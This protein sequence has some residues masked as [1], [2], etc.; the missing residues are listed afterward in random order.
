[1]PSGPPTVSVVIPTYNGARFV[2]RA[3]DSVLVQQDEVVDVVVVDD[4]STDETVDI[5]AR[6]EDVRLLRQPHRGVAAARNAGIAA[7]RAPFV[8]FCDHD[9]EWLLHKA[10]RQAEHLREDPGASAVLCFADAVCDD[11]VPWPAW[12]PRGRDGHG[13]MA[14]AAYG[15]FRAEVLAAVGGFVDRGTGLG[16]DDFDL[17]VRMKEQGLRIEV[18]EEDLV[19][20]HVHDSN[21]SNT[22]GS[23]GPGMLEVLRG[24]VHRARHMSILIIPVRY[25]PHVGGIET[26]L[27]HTLPPMRDRGFDFVIAAGVPDDTVA[28]EEM[29]GVP[30]YRLP[31]Y[32]ALRSYDPGAILD[33]G[34]RLRA[35]E[36]DHDVTLRHVHGL[37]FNMFFVARPASPR[38][39]AA[40]D[41]RA[42]DARHALPVQPDHARNARGG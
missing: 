42:R 12:L 27:D 25:A 11:G 8:G 5:V 26:L 16:N 4:G 24:R 9:D 19:R 15:L 2:G 37:D 13:G 20:Q 36:L 23:Y 3:L 33:I 41:Q 35:I 18:L 10:H 40:H 21:Y 1:M 34:Q 17:L 14:I 7:A 28:F 32:S 22:L 6:Y 31:F 29:D 38:A 30:V 39:A